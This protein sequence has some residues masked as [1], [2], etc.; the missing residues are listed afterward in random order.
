MCTERQAHV[1]SRPVPLWPRTPADSMSLVQASAPAKT[2]QAPRSRC[3][4]AERRPQRRPPTMDKKAQQYKIPGVL[5]LKKEPTTV[6]TEYI[7]ATKRGGAAV[8][9]ATE[10]C[11]PCFAYVQPGHTCPTWKRS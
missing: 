1:L 8:G 7:D 2:S 6:Y 11:R 5:D 4:L 3:N 9:S 10:F